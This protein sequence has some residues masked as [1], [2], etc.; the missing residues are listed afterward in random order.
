MK[1][2]LGNTSMKSLFLFV[3]ISAITGLYSQTIENV[4]FRALGKTIVVSYDFLHPKADTSINVVLVFIDQQGVSIVPKAISGDIK[5]VKPGEGK[6][7][8]WDVLADGIS[9]SGKYKAEVSIQRTASSV[10]IG[11]QVWATENLNVDRFRNGDPIPQ[12]KTNEEWLRAG[13][14]QQPAWCYYEND[15]KNG[16]TYGKLYNWYAVND[17]RGL[18]PPGWHIPTDEEWTQLTT[19]LGGKEVAG[20]KMKS[21]NGWNE[22]LGKIGN[23]TN[24]SGFSGL[25]GG[26]RDDGGKFLG[27]GGYGDWWS[28]S[29]TN[30][31]TGWYRSLYC[32]DGNLYKSS[33]NEAEGLSVR[34]IKD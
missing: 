16:E 1:L 28:S 18:A 17:Q 4:D 30:S 10:K 14:N 15:P 23:G 33:A 13:E 3:L 21:T 26:Y 27:V 8:T 24:T 32:D 2:K 22:Y 31:N 20:E 11:T 9:L 12:A 19:F 6:R 7:I 34:C 25:P 5:Y 29:E